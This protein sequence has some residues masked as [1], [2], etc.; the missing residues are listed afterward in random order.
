MLPQW[1]QLSG[2]ILATLEERV[3]TSI[4][5]PLSPSSADLGSLFVPNETALSSAPFPTLTNST[6]LSI[7]KPWSQHLTDIHILYLLEFHLFQ[8]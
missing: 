1:T 4:T 3:T 2:Y 6:D 7:T 5:L 8:S